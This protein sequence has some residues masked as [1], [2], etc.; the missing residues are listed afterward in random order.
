MIDQTNSTVATII[1][2]TT[3]MNFIFVQIFLSTSVDVSQ[4]SL[5]II[6]LV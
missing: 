4:L 5:M 3:F 1:R 6:S 2:D